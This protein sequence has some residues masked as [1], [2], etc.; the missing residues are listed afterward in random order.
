MII[1]SK[2]IEG[3]NIKWILRCPTK[4][5]AAEL[6]ELRIKIDGETENLDRES[7]EGL[8]TPEDFKKLIYEDS[9]AERTLFLVAEVDGKIV[10][11]TRCIGNK[12]SRF[13]HKAE[14]GICI[15][16]EYWGHGIGKVLLENVLMWAD[17]TGIEKISLTVVETNTKAIQLYKK[18]GF[19]EEG[20]LRKDRIH[21][22][23]NYYNTVI[24]GRLLNK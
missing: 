7:G 9:M 17:A 2:K 16:K 10:G 22:D 1:E 6:S 15:S 23:G 8:L 14:F 24:M 20:L 13:R 12:L 18:Y 5:D 4:N 11:F 3:K 19:V 21:K